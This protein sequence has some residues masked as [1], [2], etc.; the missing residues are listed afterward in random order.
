MT[1]ENKELRVFGEDEETEISGEF[2]IRVGTI[3]CDPEYTMKV[4]KIYRVG[5]IFE[6]T[7]IVL[8]GLED[9]DE[10]EQLIISYDLKDRINEGFIQILEY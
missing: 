6:H 4:H 5:M 10:F 8:R 3:I 9:T 7:L 1:E 2:K